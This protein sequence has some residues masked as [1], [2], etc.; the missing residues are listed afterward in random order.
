VVKAR[1]QSWPQEPEACKDR[2]F[3]DVSADSWQWCAFRTQQ[4]CSGLAVDA[5]AS[6]AMVPTRAT[7]NKKMA[8]RRCMRFPGEQ[9]PRWGSG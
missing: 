6:G 8:V 9:K 7:N 5:I 4:A 1:Q 3:E 2:W